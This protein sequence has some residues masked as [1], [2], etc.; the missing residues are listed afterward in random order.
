MQKTLR[1]LID[2]RPDLIK[3]WDYEKNT[4]NIE[5]ITVGSNKKVYWKCS[6]GHSWLAFVYNRVGKAGCPY[7]S[8]N[9]VSDINNFTTYQ[10]QLSK[11]FDEERNYPLRADQIHHKSNKKFWWKCPKEDDHIWQASPNDRSKQPGC[12]FC[13]GKRASKSYNLL[14][15]YPKLAKQWHPTKNGNLCPSDITPS[16]GKKVYWKCDISDDHEWI[17]SANSR[18]NMTNMLSCPFCTGRKICKSNCFETTHQYLLDS[19]DYNKNTLKP[20]EITYSAH[21]IIYWICQKGHSWQAPPYSRVMGKNCPECNVSKGEERIDNI[22]DSLK[23]KHRGQYSYKE[24]NGKRFDF[25]IFADTLLLIEYHG[26]QHYEP[27][28]F[29]STKISGKQNLSQNKKRD[30]WKL[31]WATKKGYPLLTIP[32]WDFDKIEA[33][34]KDFLKDNLNSDTTKNI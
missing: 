3:E 33:L 28:S 7:C 13:S 2:K 20:S 23:I 5:D 1:L 21:K 15:I 11:Q 14:K 29:G 18:V 32:Y 16:S 9:F 25:A 22:L 34:V 19:W 12:P 30:K 27:V 31:K 4:A 26:I 8:G 17:A 6:K 10:P 24:L